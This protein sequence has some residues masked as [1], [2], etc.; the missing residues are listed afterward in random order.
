MFFLAV[1]PASVG[2]ETY[3]MSMPFFQGT[4]F[5]DKSA[6][7][8][9]GTSFS[10]IQSVKVRWSG[11]I[12]AG[13][14]TDLQNPGPDPACFTIGLSDG[15][16]T[17]ALATTEW[18]GETTYPEPEIFSQESIFQLQPGE[19]WDCLLDGKGRFTI[20]LELPFHVFADPDLPPPP[21]YDNEPATGA[22][23]SVVLAIDATPIPEPSGLLALA[24][25]GLGFLATRRRR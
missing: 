13:W 8:D 23:E 11:S 9:F 16:Q 7:A 18:L 22:L 12:T 1:S 21:P 17:V 5:V 15:S 3:E 6:D 10:N 4:F 20:G 14:W 2:A 25:G 19:S 24:A